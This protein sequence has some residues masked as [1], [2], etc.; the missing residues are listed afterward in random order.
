MGWRREKNHRIST[1]TT[2]G[3]TTVPCMLT[4]DT[5]LL[6][7]LTGEAEVY[8]I[9]LALRIAQDHVEYQLEL[10]WVVRTPPRRNLS[11]GGPTVF[12]A[13]SKQDWPQRDQVHLRT[14]WCFLWSYLTSQ[15]SS[16]IINPE[17]WPEYK[18]SQGH[19]LSKTV[20]AQ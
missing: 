17:M 11:L 7:L 16:F 15:N 13:I 9:V 2:K 1:E 12:I 3:P 5:R 8:V 4:E 19:Q 6:G 10:S 20:G 18:N 14:I